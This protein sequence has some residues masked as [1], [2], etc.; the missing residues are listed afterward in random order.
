[1]AEDVGEFS[2]LSV[3]FFCEEVAETVGV[4]KALLYADQVCYGV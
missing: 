2:E 3:E 4:D 1:M